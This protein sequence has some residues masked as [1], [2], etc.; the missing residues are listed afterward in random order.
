MLL[1]FESLVR[2]S[3]PVQCSSEIQQATRGKALTENRASVTDAHSQQVFFTRSST[4]EGALWSA[5]WHQN[6]LAEFLG[7]DVEPNKE[8]IHWVMIQIWIT[9]LKIIKQVLVFLYFP[10]G[11]NTN[12]SASQLYNLPCK[13]LVHTK[14]VV[15]W[16]FSLFS[17]FI[18]LF[19]YYL[20]LFKNRISFALQEHFLN[21]LSQ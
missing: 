14:V 1:G 6:Y 10:Y 15:I 18:Y 17:P 8:G 5:K 2:L 11:R 21:E 13:P 12:Y 20:Y 19:Y 16:H 3:S 4:K 7:K 9:F